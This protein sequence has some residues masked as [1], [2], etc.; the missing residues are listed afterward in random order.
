MGA[1]AGI[2]LARGGGALG[3]VLLALPFLTRP[4]WVAER[5]GIPAETTGQIIN[6]RATWGGALLGIAGFILVCRHLRPWSHSGAWAVLTVMTGVW[7]A[8]SIGFVFDGRAD[9][10]QWFW[11]V[12]ELALA[13]LAAVYLFRTGTSVGS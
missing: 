8:R 4:L 2:G 12:A 9:R 5:L 10:L 13:S 11:W 3:L 1:L 7:F 6:V